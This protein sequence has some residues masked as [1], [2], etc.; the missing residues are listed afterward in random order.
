MNILVVDDDLLTRKVLDTCIR[1][2]GHECTCVSNGEEALRAIEENTYCLVFMDLNMPVM[3]G[4]TATKKI[5]QGAC[6]FINK[7]IPIIAATAETTSSFQLQRNGF[8][9]YLRKPF[10]FNSIEATLASFGS[11]KD[12]LATPQHQNCQS[13]CYML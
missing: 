13:R 10:F 7:R 3:D 4:I 1:K 9:N 11:C 5:R 12:Y 8:T 6:G 2:N